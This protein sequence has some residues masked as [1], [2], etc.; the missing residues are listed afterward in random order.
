[1]GLGPGATRSRVLVSEVVRAE[2]LAERRRAQSADH[3]G[4]DVKEHRAG[5]V[6]AADAVLVAQHLLKLG[7]HSVTALACLRENEV[8]L[9]LQPFEL[10]AAHKARWE[11]AGAVTK[12]LLS[13]RALCS[14]PRPAAPRRC[15]SRRRKK[16]ADEQRGRLNFAG[17]FCTVA[18]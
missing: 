17:I 4:F 9:P 18:S 2:E 15:R 14:F 13:P 11:W 7:A 10:W 6:H 16:S 12:Y 8:V 5:H 1:M 3:A